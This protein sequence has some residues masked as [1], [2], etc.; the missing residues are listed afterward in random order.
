MENDERAS[1]SVV[2][3]TV[4]ALAAEA[5]LERQASP[6]SLPAATTSVTPASNMASAAAFEAAEKPPPSDIDATEPAPCSAT[7][8]IPLMT[9]EVEPLPLSLRTLT[10]TISAL[11]DTPY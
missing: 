5:G 2:A 10:P 8:F 9:S 7:Q 11:L 1:C 4:N 3:P 6:L